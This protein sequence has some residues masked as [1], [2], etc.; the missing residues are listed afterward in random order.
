M[1]KVIKL[2]FLLFVLILIFNKQLISY[3]YSYKFSK[4]TERE[5]VFDKFD[6]DYPNKIE[7][8]GIKLKNSKNLFYDNIFESDKVTIVFELN[9][10]F[11]SNL[12]IVQSLIIEN[13][14]FFLDIFENNKTKTDNTNSSKIFEDNIGLAK[15]INENSPDKIW[16]EKRR[17]INFLIL[18]AKITGA[19]AFIK[20]ST[21]P[22]PSE[23]KLSNMQFIK[24]GN[25][26][27]YQHYKDVL[28]IILFDIMASTTEL[29]LKKILKII[30]KY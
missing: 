14:R 3:Y 26:K 25:E 16:P 27:N 11:F 2:F 23:V 1:L 19:K 20:V 28:R 6:I 18:K 13:P 29:E 9:S 4:W 10:L 7:I 15:K 5:L 12:I 8:S 17:D 24:I 30:Y 22:M 21:L